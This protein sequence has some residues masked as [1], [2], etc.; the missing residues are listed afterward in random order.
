MFVRDGIEY[1]LNR[2]NVYTGIQYKD[3]KAVFAWETG[4]ELQ[5]PQDWTNEIQ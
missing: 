5:A 2:K 3:D 1:L 4:N